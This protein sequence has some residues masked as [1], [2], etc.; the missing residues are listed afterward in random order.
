VKVNNYEVGYRIN[1]IRKDLGLNQEDFGK[2]I[3][4]AHKSLVSKWETGKN[5]P[6]NER[7]KAIAEIGGISV[8]ELLYGDMKNFTSSYFDKRISETREKFEGSFYGSIL[9]NPDYIQSVKDD[10]LY[11]VQ[12]YD[13]NHSDTEALNKLIDE[14]I[15]AVMRG[16]EYTNEGAFALAKNRLHDTVQQ[17]E[18]FFHEVVREDG[19]N[20]I[21][22]KIKNGLDPVILENL[23]LIVNHAENEVSAA[24][25]SY[26]NNDK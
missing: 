26:F 8:N 23:K 24:K 11:K 17:L 10:F 15:Y 13:L 12:F 7:L 4:D 9:N 1:S 20:R 14:S 3:S 19:K 21:T 22:S 16:E 2:R 5:L 6:N 18:E 25:D